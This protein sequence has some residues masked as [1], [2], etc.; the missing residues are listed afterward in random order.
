MTS[1]LKS[2][3]ALLALA[4]LV[5]LA[6][7]A[8]RFPAFVEPASLANV[9]NDLKSAEINIQEV[10]NLIFE[11]TQTACCTLKLDAQPPEGT[12]RSIAGRTSEVIQA[13]LV[14]L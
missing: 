6:V 13:Q 14:K 1:F 11:G 8:S 2:R 7:I 9:F 4:N 10:E 3:E 5:L 12:I